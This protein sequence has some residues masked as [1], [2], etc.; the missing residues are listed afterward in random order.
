MLA[1]NEDALETLWYWLNERHLIYLKKSGGLPKPWTDDKIL[2][3]WK[4]CNV[5]RNLDKTSA[6][7]INHSLEPNWDDSPGMIVFNCFAFR[8]FNWVPTYE[9]ISFDNWIPIWNTED[10]KKI[11]ARRVAREEKLISSAYMIRGYKNQPKH[12]SIPESLERIW[13][14]KDYLADIAKSSNS[15]KETMQVVLDE[16]Y[17]GWGP[18]TAY[19]VILDLSYTWILK[20]A[21]DLDTWC[22]FGPGAKHG[23]EAI[24]PGIKASEYLSHTRWLLE[25]SPEFLGDHVPFLNLQDVEYALCEVAKYLRIRGGGK[26]KERYSGAT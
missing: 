4:F 15:L 17:W 21:V 26:M 5:F 14:D 24:F 25:E 18:F 23:L 16:S 9:A 7:F 10:V 13:T 11:L 1:P 20:N 19:Q 22:S 6:W 3:Q 2:Q 12:L 8:A